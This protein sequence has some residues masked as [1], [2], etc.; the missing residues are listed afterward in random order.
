MADKVLTISV[1]GYN[2]EGYIKQT[3]DSCLIPSKDLLEVIVVDDGATDS[4]AAIADSYAERFPDIFRVVRKENGGYG[5]TVNT[6]ID[7]ARGKYF[8]ILDGDD[9][10]DQDG[11][12]SLVRDLCEAEVD[13]FITPYERCYEKKSELIDQVES[14]KSGI[15]AFDDIEISWRLSMHAIGYRTDILRQSGLRLTEHCFYTDIEY[16]TYPLSYVEKVYVSHIP[17]Y[18][19]RIGREG[20]SVAIDGLIKHRDDLKKITLH[21][22][23]TYKSLDN[24]ETVIARIIRA[25][26][27]DCTVWYFHA[28]FCM[29]RSAETWRT[30]EDF[31]T[32]AFADENIKATIFARSQWGKIFSKATKRS[33]PF[34]AQASRL[35]KK[36][37]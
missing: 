6:S 36:V 32:F 18:Q 34:I 17:V 13:L 12:E 25:W 14:T 1:A 2:V 24:T 5:S 16:A 23:D 7:L 4:T 31:Q 10:F 19:Y 3:L 11:L 26:L 21:V 29:E 22:F 15:H 37:R 27:V 9:W 20:Q 28:L 8:K 33:Y 30:I 35:Y